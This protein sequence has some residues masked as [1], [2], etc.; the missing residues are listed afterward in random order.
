M[1]ARALAY[2]LLIEQAL[3]ALDVDS[4][5][6]L[7]HNLSSL[8]CTQIWVK[9]S[10]EYYEKRGEAFFERTAFR[11]LS[12]FHDR[13]L[14]LLPK[15]ARLLDAGCGSGRDTKVFRE[16][17]YPTTAFDAS[18]EMVR[19]ASAFTEGPILHM[20]FQEMA[21]QGAF[22]GIWANASLLH[23]PYEELPSVLE[24]FDHALTPSGILHASF[25]YGETMRQEPE[26]TFYDLDEVTCP[27]YFAP[28]FDLLEV[29]KEE[30][31]SGTPQTWLRILARKKNL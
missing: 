10:L 27:L 24:R 16:R 18:K 28:F 30:D 25:K 19:L 3:E 5:G 15:G 14:A 4:L 11:D 7:L 6:D 31:V 2:I 22:E 21:F 26:R 20:R 13:F 12:W 9:M 8:S 17:G 29:R 1:W 23:V